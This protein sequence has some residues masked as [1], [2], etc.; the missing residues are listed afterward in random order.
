M[1]S[2]KRG[3]VMRKFVVLTII[4]SALLFGASFDCTKATTNVEKMI[5]QNESLSK[6]DE[7]LSQS[8][9]EAMQQSTD[10]E[11]LKKVQLGWLKERNTCKSV[12]CIK[13]KYEERLLSFENAQYIK[14]LK[15]DN[16]TSL[17]Y[18]DYHVLIADLQNGKYQINK[19]CLQCQKNEICKAFIDDINNHN[20]EWLTPTVQTLDF[21][22]ASLQEYLKSFSS[23]VQSQ[24]EERVYLT[25]SN[26]YFDTN[27]ENKNWH[28]YPY[29]A[30]WVK[31]YAIN[32]SVNPFYFILVDGFYNSNLGLFGER[33]ENDIPYASSNSNIDNIV[34]DAGHEA[35][36]IYALL[37]K[38]S[39]KIDKFDYV[40]STVKL[41]KIMSPIRELIKYHEQIYLLE[42][43]YDFNSNNYHSIVLY[44]IE[45][46]TTDK[47]IVLN[48]KC[49]FKKIE[50]R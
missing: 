7:N 40:E 28:D 14:Q 24:L 48:G 3:G 16:N 6:L 1:K 39:K 37:D 38:N 35:L 44:P 42:A 33:R 31:L 49:I 4:L 19:Q 29:K 46:Q 25:A 2:N 18:V 8:F 5:C 45:N 47:S 10:K 30:K 21:N 17:Y 9:K 32:D 22:D 34:D 13:Q 43:N 50:E 36:G 12:K 26:R 27:R 11:Q 15:I 20:I 41:S 23:W